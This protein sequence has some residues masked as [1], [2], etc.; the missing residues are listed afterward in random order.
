M[1]RREFLKSA[2]AI[3]ITGAAF[4]P[5]AF[6]AF[7]KP[8][9]CV[10]HGSNIP[11]M[12]AAGIERFGGWNAIVAKGQKATLKPNVAWA[13][14]PESGANTHP[15][16][17]TACVVGCRSAGALETIIVENPCSNP[18]QSFSMSG[19]EAAVKKVGGRMYAAR[20]QS[21]F[22]EVTLPKAKVM[23]T[24]MVAKDV[25]E[26]GCLVNIP[27]AKTHGSAVLT[28]GMK[29][30][31]GSVLDRRFMHA[32]NL[33]QCIADLSTLIKPALVIV[34]AIR[35]MLNKG[36]RGPGELA[37][38]NQMIFGRDPVAVDAYATTL[39][40]KKPFDVPCIKIAHEMGV[41]IGDLALIDVQKIEV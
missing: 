30:W 39:F 19:V 21:H 37:Y 16:V 27:V 5:G 6:G 8:V 36:P 4:G 23:K 38:P 15:D 35:I 29:N 24:A 12:V 34:D 41:G 3:G 20:D 9:V 11:A 7:D 18:K 22:V 1:N 28:L 17:V 10:V 2:T 25:M 32:N 40:G 13:S 14:G 31:M 33:H 26:T